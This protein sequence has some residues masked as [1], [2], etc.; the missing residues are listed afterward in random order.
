MTM[1]RIFSVS[2]LGTVALFALIAFGMW[3]CPQYGVYEQSLRGTAELRRA[4]Q[5]R[6]I[7][8]QEAHARLESA[9][10]DAEAEIERAKGVSKANEIVALGLGGP[11]G[12]LRYLYI[13]TLNENAKHLGQV[14]Y[15]PTEAG[16]PILE[17]K[18][19]KA[20]TEAAR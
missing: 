14:I 1:K 10:L 15:I 2:T 3:G 6:Q 8:V 18:R 4:E 7:R 17:A 9:K 16:L 20:P 5:N 12:Y 19:L 13:Q 11:E